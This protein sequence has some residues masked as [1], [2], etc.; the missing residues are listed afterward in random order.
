MSRENLSK[1][2][3]NRIKTEVKPGPLSIWDSV[4]IHPVLWV[5]WLL[6]NYTKLTPNQITV[7]S[8]IFGLAS[9]FCFLQGTWIYLVIGAC[10][11]EA[12]YVFDCVDGKIAKLKGLASP[13]GA[14]LD[15]TLDMT[16]HFL[17]VLCLIYGQYLATGSVSYFF[18]GMTYIFLDIVCITSRYVIGANKPYVSRDSEDLNSILRDRFPFAHKI[19]TSLDSKNL[20][21]MPLCSVEAE[22]IAFFIAPILMKI[23]FG[24]LLGAI[25]LAGNILITVSFNFLFKRE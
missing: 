22:T 15:I 14:Y 16:R 7:I 12:S 13:F 6:A 23:E 11:F 17:I 25:I 1:Y 24:L 3:L 5:T 10:L 19:K 2:T 20:S 18:L 8:F 4:V 9:A 21:I